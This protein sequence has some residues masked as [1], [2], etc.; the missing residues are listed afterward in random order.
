MIG[1]RCIGHSTYDIHTIYVASDNWESITK[2]KQDLP[3]IQ[4]NYLESAK[5]VETE[6][7]DNIDHQYT[8]FTNKDMLTETLVD[9]L[10][11]AKST[12]LLHRISNYANFALL[13]S[14]TI[15]HSYNLSTQK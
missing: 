15:T 1:K 13:R 14:T 8:M 11:L 10:L 5:R 12:Y 3:D 2:L 4:I 9:V 6:I 7:G